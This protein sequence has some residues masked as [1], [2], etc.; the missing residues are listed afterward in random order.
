MKISKKN[1]QNLIEKELRTVLSEQA[2][3]PPV[4]YGDDG[5]PQD[6]A[7]IDHAKRIEILEKQMDHVGRILKSLI[8]ISNTLKDEVFRR[9]N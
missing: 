6:S 4:K 7:L 2:L 5:D 9:R 1:L 8:N 3:E